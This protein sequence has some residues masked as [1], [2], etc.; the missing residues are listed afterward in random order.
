MTHELLKS[1]PITD[2]SGNVVWYGPDWPD[3]K[4]T[5]QVAGKIT[6]PA[7]WSHDPDELVHDLFA[8]ILWPEHPLGR[9]VIGR[10]EVIEALT[11]E[12][13]VS[14]LQE[15]YLPSRMVIAAAGNLDDGAG[16]RC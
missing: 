5:D 9:S 6:N 1:R 3:H 10:A 13:I 15:Q 8:E 2:D 14:F 7:A 16:R 11:R 12:Q 4:V